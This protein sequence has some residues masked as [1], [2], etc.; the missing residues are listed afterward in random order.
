MPFSNGGIIAH[1]VRKYILVTNSV[2]EVSSGLRICTALK[3]SFSLCSEVLCIYSDPS[4][5]RTLVTGIPRFFRD[6]KPNVAHY[7]PLKLLL[8]CIIIVTIILG[9]VFPP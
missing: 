2:C 4:I 7:F 9:I 3:F 8:Q 1:F 5:I 6:I